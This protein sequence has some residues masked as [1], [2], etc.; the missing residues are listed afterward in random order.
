MRSEVESPLL[1]P[2]GIKTILFDLDGTLRHSQPSGAAVFTEYVA[3]RGYPISEDDRQRA[4]RWEHY[5]WANSPELAADVGADKNEDQQFWCKYSY[6]RLVA[7]GLSATVAKSLAPQVCQHMEASYR[8][9]NVV[10]AELPGVL[11]SLQVAGYRLGVV[12]NR[13]HPFWELLQEM[14]LCPFFDFSLAGGEVKSWKPEPGIFHAAL[15]R[16]DSTAAQ[17]LYVGDNYFADVV[18]ARRAGLRPVLYDPD[19]LFH[20][21]GC[22]VITS[23]DGLIELIGQC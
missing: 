4:L 5:Y 14:G 3:G 21:P 19:G 20:E 17:T 9:E 23:F 8:P 15:E 1:S 7:L 16:A 11:A 18:G 12:S 2:N 22:P 10:P 13:D 6:R